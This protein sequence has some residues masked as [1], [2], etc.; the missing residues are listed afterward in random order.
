[1][2]AEKDTVSLRGERVHYLGQTT[3]LEK[4]HKAFITTENHLGISP[5][6]CLAL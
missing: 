3:K 1:M 6:G 2:G 5:F 4:F